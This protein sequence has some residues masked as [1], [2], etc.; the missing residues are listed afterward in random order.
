MSGGSTSRGFQDGGDSDD[1]FESAAPFYAKYRRP[2]PEAVVS[3]LV[4]RFGLD[5]RGRLLDVGCGTGQVFQVIGKYFEEVVAI[6]P[7]K[8][9]ARYAAKTAAACGLNQVTVLPL[10]GE[11]IDERLGRFRMAIFG[12]SFHWM[13]RQ[14]VGNL[15]YDRLDPGGHLVVLSPG[16]IDYSGTTEWEAEIRVML[17]EWL[18]P[19]RRAG[20]GVYRAGERHGDALR[21]TRF[22]EAEETDIYVQEQWSIDQIVGY[23]FSTSYAS[24]AVLGNKAEGFERS[25]RERLLRLRPDGCFEKRAEYTAIYATRF[26]EA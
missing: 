26:R 16:G 3:Y 22:R 11:K 10:R 6:D 12:A 23:L 13:D 15:V 1:L 18:G 24:Q 5:G 19:E 14:C 2:Y 17:E 4:Q 8:E 7:D 20:Q 9:M 25:V 21:K